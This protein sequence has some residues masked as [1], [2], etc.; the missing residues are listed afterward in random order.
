MSYVRK[1]ITNA[2]AESLNQT[3]TVT[4]TA[5][6]NA[7]SLLSAFS[8]YD[9]RGTVS[10]S[11]SVGRAAHLVAGIPFQFTSSGKRTSATAYKSCSSNMLEAKTTV[12]GTTVEYGVNPST[13]SAT[14]SAV[15]G[16]RKINITSRGVFN[17]AGA[18][19]GYQVALSGSLNGSFTTQLG[20]PIKKSAAIAPAFD[21]VEPMFVLW[22]YDA[23]AFYATAFDAAGL[24]LLF[25]A[26]LPA[27]A[28]GA[29]VIG[30]GLGLGMW[31]LFGAGGG[32]G[33]ED[34]LQ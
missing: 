23:W 27:F 15:A 20:R 21:H 1:P 34:L 12:L 6:I 14:G 29:A 19:T 24:F 33:E 4:D 18:A 17:S 16:S 3:A 11:F 7:N 8:G 9:S 22:N 25:G 28:A 13:H 26:G 2:G 10:G 32:G 30:L 5:V 31:G